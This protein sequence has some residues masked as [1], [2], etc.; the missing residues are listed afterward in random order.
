MIASEEG[1]H[2]LVPFSS[3]QCLSHL[4]ELLHSL[5]SRS[6]FAFTEFENLQTI[7]KCHKQIRP[8]IWADSF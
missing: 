5:A 3:A 6:V 1:G 2:P 8:A 7:Q 4:H